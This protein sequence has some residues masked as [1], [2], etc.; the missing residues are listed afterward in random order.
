[1]YL[2]GLK[3]IGTSLGFLQRMEMKMKAL[4]RKDDEIKLMTTI[5]LPS[6]HSIPVRK[7]VRAHP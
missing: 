3:K 4:A 1:M 7:K 6:T 2:L 5:P